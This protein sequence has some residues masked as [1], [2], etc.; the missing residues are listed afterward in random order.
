MTVSELANTLRAMHR[1]V[2][3]VEAA[4]CQPELIEDVELRAAVSSQCHQ[5]FAHAIRKHLMLFDEYICNLEAIAEVGWGRG[6]FLFVVAFC[7]AKCWS[8]C[9]HAVLIPCRSFITFLPWK[10]VVVFRF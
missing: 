7:H 8:D 3:R 1:F 2:H 9:C 6:S 5:A 4:G 10:V